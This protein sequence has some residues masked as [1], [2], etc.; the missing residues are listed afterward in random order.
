MEITD[1]EKRILEAARKVFASDG[2]VG[3]RMQRIADVAGM[4]KASL[5]YYFRSK[6]KLFD[7]IFEEYMDRIVPLLSTWQDDSDDWQSKVK[8]FVHD[9]MQVFRDTSILFLAQELRRDPK[10]LEVRLAAKRNSPNIFIKYYER[11][12]AS[13]LVRQQDPRVLA[14]AMHS[15][16]AYPLMNAPMMCGAL[17][18]NA[19]DYDKFL[20]TYAEQA[21]DLL[22]RV[23]KK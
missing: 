2:Y 4:S 3:A 9:L 22:I 1:P 19:N 23:M 15:M 5:H 11:L 16:C 21:A 12:Q 7:R 6:E 20:T 14:V 8:R 10:K 13:G 18:M 17:R